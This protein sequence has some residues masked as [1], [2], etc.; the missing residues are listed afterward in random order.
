MDAVANIG[1][2][3]GPKG[4]AQD[5]PSQQRFDSGKSPSH[6]QKARLFGRAFDARYRNRAARIVRPIHG[7]HPYALRASGPTLRVVQICSR[8]ICHCEGMDAVA[9]I[10]AADGP[11]GEAQDVP[12]Q[13]G[14]SPESLPAIRKKPAFSGGLFAY[15][16]ETRIRT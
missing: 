4:E 2:A 8:Q 1:A 16:W 10:G 7:A 6:T 11:K 3:D 9:N 12:S 14:S 15:G 5:V 13:R